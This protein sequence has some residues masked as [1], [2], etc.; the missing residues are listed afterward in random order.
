MSKRL[1][2]KSEQW[3]IDGDCTVCRRNSYCKQ[4]CIANKRELQKSESKTIRR[5]NMGHGFRTTGE[6][7]G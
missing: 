2:D 1:I 5:L 6:K 7:V 3:K 4:R